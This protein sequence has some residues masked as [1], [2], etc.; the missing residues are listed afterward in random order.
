M[1]GAV[2]VKAIHFLLELLQVA[3]SVKVQLR[4]FGVVQ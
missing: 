2:A 1:C 3:V 4:W